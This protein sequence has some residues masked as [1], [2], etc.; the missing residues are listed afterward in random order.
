M[1]LLGRAGPAEATSE[2]K[3]NKKKFQI[4]LNSCVKNAAKTAQN[5]VKSAEIGHFIMF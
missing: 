4:G 5:M 2:S 3:H 1:H